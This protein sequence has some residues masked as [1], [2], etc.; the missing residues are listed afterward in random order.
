MGKPLYAAKKLQATRLP[1]Q[2]SKPLA[3]PKNEKLPH[4]KVPITQESIFD[5][6]LKKY[7]HHWV[8]SFNGTRA[9]FQVHSNPSLVFKGESP[10]DVLEKAL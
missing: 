7:E 6:L 5:Q 4:P 8:L 1:K 3:V 9:V 2:E 10:L